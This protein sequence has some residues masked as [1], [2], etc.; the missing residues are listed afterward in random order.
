M[1]KKG[2]EVYRLANH[3]EQSATIEQSLFKLSCLQTMNANIYSMQH[4]F[5]I[6]KFKNGRNSFNIKNKKKD[7]NS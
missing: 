4:N 5:M 1:I 6:E 7:R 3:I 2:V